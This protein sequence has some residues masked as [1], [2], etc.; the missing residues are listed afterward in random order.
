MTNSLE[1]K[2]GSAAKDLRATGKAMLWKWPTGMIEK[3]GRVLHTQRTGCDFFG[4]DRGGKVVMVECKICKDPL[5][6]LNE[7]N[8]L[9]P[10]QFDALRN[11]SRAG[12]HALIV[13]QHKDEVAVFSV[14]L[15]SM[16][17][18][19]E[20][21]MSLRWDRISDRLK[22]PVQSDPSYWF[23]AFFT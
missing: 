18:E 20:D 9:R 19:E 3:D 13:W 17:V 2:I 16:A 5:L 22:R 12:G 6:K 14:D 7:R 21:R 10:H 15:Y 11:C 8:G 1:R 4:Y 23:T